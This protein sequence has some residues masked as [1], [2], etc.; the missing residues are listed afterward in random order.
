MLDTAALLGRGKCREQLRQPRLFAAENVADLRSIL[1]G[2]ER[3]MPREDFVAGEEQFDRLSRLQFAAFM[4]GI[5]DLRRE[6]LKLL[7]LVS[8][9]V[10]RAG[11]LI[12]SGHLVLEMACSTKLFDQPLAGDRRCGEQHDGLRPSWREAGSG[13]PP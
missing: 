6:G 10:E 3:L 8:Q 12:Q 13:H 4:R 1:A 9:I 7:D 11:N 5:L 2:L